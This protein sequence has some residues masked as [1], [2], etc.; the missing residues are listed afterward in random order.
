MQ[1]SHRMA[2]KMNSFTYQ[3]H[4][5]SENFQTNNVVLFIILTKS[6]RM[7]DWLSC[8]CDRMYVCV[9]VYLHVSMHVCRR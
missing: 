3:V 1:A 9:G 2:N 6:E 4:F 5:H 8:E 7:L